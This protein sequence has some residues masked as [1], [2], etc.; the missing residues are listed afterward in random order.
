MELFLH[1]KIVMFN[2]NFFKGIH[3]TEMA[4]RVN[5]SVGGEPVAIV[6]D[7]RNGIEGLKLI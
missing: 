5:V 4:Q 7:Q 2:A 1:K 3:N 6:V